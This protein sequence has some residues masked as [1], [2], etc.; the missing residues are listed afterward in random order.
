MPRVKPSLTVQLCNA[1]VFSDNLEKN[2]CVTA[3]ACVCLSDTLWAQL[4]SPAYLAHR[5]TCLYSTR[6]C[7]YKMSC[8][9][10][11][12]RQ[13]VSTASLVA[14]LGR[15]LLLLPGPLNSSWICFSQSSHLLTHK[16]YQRSVTVS[17]Y[18]PDQPLSLP[19]TWTVITTHH[20]LCCLSSRVV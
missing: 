5:L 4:H 7:Q 20:P 19:P 18:L 13:I 16:I 1:V 9:P 12:H 8:L 11:S 6:Q 3:P 10:C 15:L 14:I 17:V 2:Y